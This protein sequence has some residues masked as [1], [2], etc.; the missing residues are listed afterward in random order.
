MKNLY[1]IK[2]VL[3]S[4][5]KVIWRNVPGKILGCLLQNM[6]EYEVVRFENNAILESSIEAILTCKEEDV[7][8]KRSKKPVEIKL[9]VAES[10]YE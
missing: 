3:K 5:E 1:A 8:L 4:G 2:F 10:D 9:K 6:G 7:F